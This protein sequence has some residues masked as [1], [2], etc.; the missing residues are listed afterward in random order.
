MFVDCYA[1]TS[2]LGRSILDH[3]DREGCR[4]A[5]IHG[6]PPFTHAQYKTVRLGTRLATSELKMDNQLLAFKNCSNFTDEQLTAIALFR[7][8]TAAAC[9]GI[10]FLVLV[11][12]LV[13]ARF[14]YQRV[15][16][17]VL[18]HLTLGFTA[19]NILYQLV[20]ALHLQY[21]LNPHDLKFCEA[22]AF[23]DQYLESVLLMFMLEIALVL[24]LK[25]LHISTSWEF[26]DVYFEKVKECK[27]VC[28]GWKINKLEVAIFVLAVTLPLLFEWIP[29]TTNSYGP[30]GPW[31]WIRASEKYC[32]PSSVGILE[33]VWLWDVPFVGIAFLTSLLF[34]VSLY[35]LIHGIRNAKVEKLALIEVGITNIVFFLTFLVLAVLWCLQ[36]TSAL[37]SYITWLLI[38]ITIP[39]A[40]T[41]AS[42]ATLFAIHSPLS[43]MIACTCC[44]HQ[45][46]KSIY[47]VTTIDQSTNRHQPS[48]TTWDTPHSSADSEITP[49]ICDQQQPNY[50]S[51]T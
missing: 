3:A 41:V 26:V 31:C 50:G 37:S 42:L 11:T 22:D 39:L 19:T 36:Q 33:Q 47:D 24:F 4:R 49:L 27:F 46:Q 48:S 45:R 40:P 16:G 15:C 13:L 30:L 51:N 20:L 29:F 23:L 44:K 9:C 6:A 32:T 12:L 28:C 7:G 43:F 35:L 10:L 14:H 21:Y 2:F 8:V 1:L 38:A 17:S 5:L 18:K 34:T 25:V